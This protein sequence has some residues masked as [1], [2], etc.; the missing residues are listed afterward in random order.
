MTNIQDNSI[1]HVAKDNMKGVELPVIIGDRVTI[2]MF[3]K[4]K[5]Y[6]R[7]VARST[8]EQYFPSHIFVGS[9]CVVIHW[10]HR[11]SCRHITTAKL[12]LRYR[13]ITIAVESGAMVAAGALVT[14]GTVVPAGQ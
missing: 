10:H 6:V 2:G 3:K 12:C 9:K 7:L 13:C 14:S 1:V 8:Y 11:E 5:T 4:Q